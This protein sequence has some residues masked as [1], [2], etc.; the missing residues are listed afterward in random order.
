MLLKLKGN[1]TK[2]YF[3]ITYLRNIGDKHPKHIKYSQCYI[4]G[5]IWNY[6]TLELKDALG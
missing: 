6:C 2:I 1:D 5:D 3:T 4:V